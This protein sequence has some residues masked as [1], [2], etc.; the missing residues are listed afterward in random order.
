VGA[1][2]VRNLDAMALR[3][4][5]KVIDLIRAS[6]LSPDDLEFLANKCLSM[7]EERKPA[8]KVTP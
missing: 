5:A 3:E 7:A 8:K 2:K 4:M 6:K 1:R